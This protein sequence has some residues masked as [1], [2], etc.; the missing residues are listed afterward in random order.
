MSPITDPSQVLSILGFFLTL[1]GLL[2]SFFYIHLSDWYREILSLQVK[3]EMNKAG[4]D[5]DQKAARRSCRYEAEQYASWTTLATSLAVTIYIGLIGVLSLLIWQQ[6]PVDNPLS[7][8][9]G[10]A[11]GVFLAVYLGMTAFFLIAGYTK[12]R[13]LRSE[14]IQ[15]LTPRHQGLDRKMQ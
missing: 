14:V 5:P 9:I 10:I 8:Y 3:W 2:G 7:L 15:R 11:G 6:Q 13:R 1:A 12:V 4:D